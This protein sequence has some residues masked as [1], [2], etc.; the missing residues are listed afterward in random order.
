MIIDE[1]HD[2]KQ[3]RDQASSE[4]IRVTAEAAYRDLDRQV[5]RKLPPQQERVDR[6]VRQ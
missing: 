1:Q 3:V 2:A 5:K 6:E 4:D